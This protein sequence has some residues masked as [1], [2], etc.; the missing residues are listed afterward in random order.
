MRI[1]EIIRVYLSF[2]NSTN[3]KPGRGRT[4]TLA[5]FFRAKKLRSRYFNFIHRVIKK[6]A[7]SLNNLIK[8]VHEMNVARRLTHIHPSPL[9][10][11][12]LGTKMQP[13]RSPTCTYTYMA[14]ADVA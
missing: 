14:G 10:L 4:F 3:L 2:V 8:R 13:P 6:L 5:T 1:S 12:N 9:P 11:K 7:R